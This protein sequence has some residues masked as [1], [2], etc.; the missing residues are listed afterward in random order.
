[1]STHQD[2]PDT[3]K[4]TQCGCEHGHDDSSLS[5]N[6]LVTISGILTSVGNKTLGIKP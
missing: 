6:V 4:S 2:H 5:Q 1:M 3:D